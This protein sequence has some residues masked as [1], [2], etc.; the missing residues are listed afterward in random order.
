MFAGVRK[1]EDAKS[2]K[3]EASDRLKP[4]KIDVAKERS[5]ATAARNV[6]KALGD[7]GLVGLVNNAGIGGGGPV[8]FVDLD[9]LRET[10]EVNVIGQDGSLINCEAAPFSDLYPIVDQGLAGL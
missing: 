8:E 6:K 7:E 3:E 10:L 2:L 5:V 1:D 9:H 4:I